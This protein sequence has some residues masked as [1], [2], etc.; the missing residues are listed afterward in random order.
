MADAVKEYWVV[1]RET[2]HVFV[3]DFT[4]VGLIF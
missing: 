2:L 1:G 4:I 3:P